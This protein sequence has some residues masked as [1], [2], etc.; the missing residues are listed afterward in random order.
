MSSLF[1]PRLAMLL[2]V[3][4]SS[5]GE[6]HGQLVPAQLRQQQME[7]VTP[8]AISRFEAPLEEQYRLG[9]GD[10]LTIEVWDHPELSSRHT[11]GP[12]GRITL[13][14][15][16]DVRL[17]GHSRETARDQVKK[18][19]SALYPD[20][21]VTIRVDN[22]RSNR[23]Y[24]LGRVMNPGLIYFDT[25]PSLLETI[26]RAGGLPVGGV[27]SDKAKLTRCAIFRG[28]DTAIWV[29]LSELL[30]GNMALNIR[31]YA[32]DLVYIP[33]A[34]DQ[35]V[36][37]MGEVRQP[38][39]VNLTPEMTFLDVLALAGGPS[40]DAATN[41]MRLIRPEQGINQKISLKDL[42][43]PQPD[44]NYQI[45][46]GDILYIPKRG[47][48]RVDYWIDKLN[49]FATFLFLGTAVR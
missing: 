7:F 20:L 19:Y 28:K 11:I 21:I 43:H 46:K 36:Y 31:L 44:L 40:P 38:G 4:L 15:A 10:E 9:V 35:L 27:G 32:N 14:V 6:G 48:A 24:I 39:A 34:D 45:Q 22:Y 2:A 29:N 33:D 25:V 26:T 47:I 17:A 1:Y 30:K 5:L 41:N 3:L 42:T 23:V 13:P 18:L 37:V 12:D 8:E 16:G 49:P